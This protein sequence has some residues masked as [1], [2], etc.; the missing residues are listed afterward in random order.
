ML[1]SALPDRRHGVLAV[2]SAYAAWG[3][4][5]IYFKALRA[6]PLEVLVHRIVWSALFLLAINAFS[7]RWDWLRLLRSPRVVAASALSAALLSVNWFVYIWAVSNQRVIDGSLGYFITP[8]VQV[9]FAVALLREPLRGLQWLAL[10]TAASGVL[11]L[12]LQFGQL[13]WVGLTLAAS[14]GTYAVL[15]KT[16]RL[17]ALEGLAL[18]TWLMFPLAA[19]YLLWLAAN[20]QSSFV[21]GSLAERL[22][23]MCAG[24]LTSIPLLLFA[25]GARRIPLSLT[26]VLQYISPTEQL[27]LGVLLWQE[28]FQPIKLFGYALIWLALL[29]FSAESLWVWRRG[30][31]R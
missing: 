10:A 4:F 12:T 3:V 29:I 7:G 8:L 22:A 11:W 6:A 14:F 21:A 27:L 26:G 30:L 25:A 5:P 20:G 1:Q 31:A 15:R 28:P 19:G 16:Q 13:P 9:L 18:E 17:G 2:L 24:P 23:L